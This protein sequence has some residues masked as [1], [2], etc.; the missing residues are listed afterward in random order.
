MSR[1]HD[2]SPWKI[3]AH[4]YTHICQSDGPS[5]SLC[6]VLSCLVLSCLVLSCLVLSCLVLSCLVLSCLVLSCLVLSCLVLS[7]LVLSCLVLSCLVKVKEYFRVHLF[8]CL[9]HLPPH[10]RFFVFLSRW[11]LQATNVSQNDTR[12]PTRTIGWSVAATRGLKSTRTPPERGKKSEQC[13]ETRTIWE[14]WAVR[15]WG[16][17]RNKAA[18]D[19]PHGRGSERD[20]VLE[21]GKE[22]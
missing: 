7:C 20:G 2:A 3:I 10:V 18:G 4:T 14:F 22:I 6:L 13:V 17:W 16:V 15:R 19:P 12:G 21:R 5:C 9:S 1:R 11:G 8:S